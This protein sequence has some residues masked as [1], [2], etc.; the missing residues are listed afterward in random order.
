MHVNKK[1]IARNAIDAEKR[2][3]G[4]CVMMFVRMNAGHAM[5]KSVVTCVKKHAGVVTLKRTERNARIYV[6][7]AGIVHG[8]NVGVRNFVKAVKN[9][10]KEYTKKSTP[11]HCHVICVVVVPRKETKRKIIVLRAVINVLIV[12]PLIILRTA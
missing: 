12:K 2:K 10:R 7:T 4:I 8:M 11:V 6:K 3:K 5:M 9:A 1:K